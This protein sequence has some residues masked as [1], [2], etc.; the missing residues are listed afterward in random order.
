MSDGLGLSPARSLLD[1]FKLRL[2]LMFPLSHFLP[3]DT[4]LLLA[5]KFPLVP[6]VFEAE[7]K[8]SSLLQFS[9]QWSI[10]TV[11]VLNEV[12]LPVLSFH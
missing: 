9:P 4:T 6:T 3:T 10:S 7:S 1:Q 2:L 8:L 5:Y 12:C 11:M